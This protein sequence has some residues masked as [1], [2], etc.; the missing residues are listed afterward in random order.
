MRYN[1]AHPMMENPV[2][3]RF[4]PGAQLGPYR[5]EA[6]LGAGGMG[7]VFRARDTRLN[8]TVAIKVLPSDKTAD[9]ERKRRLLQ[10]ARAAS[11]LNHPNIVTLHDIAHDSG[12]DYLVMEYVAGTSLDRIITATGLPVAEALGYGTQIASALAAAHA[13]GIVHRDIKPANVIVTAES[14]VKVLDFGL[15]KLTEGTATGA[16]SEA[17]TQHS[18]LTE[19]GMVLGTVAYMSPEQASA[20]PV[21]HRTDIFSLGVVLAEMLTGQRPFQGKSNV[22]TMHAIINDPAPVLANQPPELEEVLAKALAKDAKDRYQHAGDLALDLRRFKG[23]WETKSLPSMRPAA[24]ATPAKRGRTR[25]WAT[26]TVLGAIIGV[27]GWFMRGTPEAMENPLANAKFTRLTDFEGIERD[28]AISS[29]GKFVVFASDRDGPFDLWLSQITSGRFVNL[30]QGKEPN[31]DTVLRIAGFSTDGSDVWF[32]N[33]S[34]QTPIRIMPFMGGPSRIFLGKAEAKRNPINVAWS[35][36]GQRIV[37][38]TSDDG[39]PL[40]VADRTGGGARQIFIDPDRVRHNHYPIWSVDG[41]WIFFVHGFP[42]VGE[43]DLW[44]IRPEGGEPERLTQHNSVVSYPAQIDRRTLMYVARDQDGSGPWLWAL[45]LARKATRRV[46]FGLEKYTSVAA[47]ADGRRLAATVSN[48]TAGL[49][50]VPILDRIAGEQDVKPFSVATV[51]ALAPRFRGSDLFYLSSRGTGDG[52]WRYQNGQALEIWKGADG[53]LLEPA[54]VSPDGRRVAIVLRRS[55][56][57]RLNLMTADGSPLQP[58]AETIDI[59]GA[60]DWS[61]DG[62]WIVT[63]GSDMDGSGLFKIPVSGGS[64]VRLAKVPSSNPAWSPDGNLIVYTGANL[65]ANAPLLAM[66]PDGTPVEL[67]AIEIRREGQRVRFLPGGKG[68]IYMQGVQRSQDFWLLDLATK[69]TRPLTHLNN[70]AAMLTFDITPDGKQIVFDRLREN[71]DIVL[72]DLPK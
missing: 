70:S 69:Q 65:S 8:R 16:L 71:S 54:A 2:T 62:N 40:F 61:P 59:R 63:A 38:H 47:T 30:T 13:A 7:E 3:S 56:R 17:Q 57:L 10:E 5:I 6:G 22:E 23:A 24:D 32:H 33:A 66:R 42:D 29:D 58:L 28:A 18:A 34:G 12:V 9:P 46:S 1:H 39:D 37:Y 21:D 31:L 55:G 52:L 51:R 4:T 45:D 35:P 15:A 50:S 14:Q 49:I 53:A 36:D 68:L 48:P 27:A 43:M 19:A 64:P 26:A 25:V 44:R 67:P 41:E 72:I 60:A 11:A 20:R